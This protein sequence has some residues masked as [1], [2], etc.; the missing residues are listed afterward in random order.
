MPPLTELVRTPHGVTLECLVTG[1]GEPTT[2]FAHG[3]GATITE[4]RPLGSGVPGRKVFFQFRGHGA[5]DAP[6]EPWT[7]GDLARDLRAIADQT[8]ATRALGVS[9]GAGALCRLLADSPER[10]DRVVLFL[11]A[12][13]DRPRPAPAR[14]RLTRLR[15]AIAAGDPQPLA[16]LVL[17]DVHPSVQDTPAA[18]AFVRA[19]IDALLRHGLAAGLATL[20][21]QVPVPD[22]AMLAEVRAEVLILATRDDDMHPVSVAEELAA[23]LPH[24]T[25]HVYDEPGVVWVQRTDLRD[26]ISGFLSG[27]DGDLSGDGDPAGGDGDPAGGADP[28]DR[29]GPPGHR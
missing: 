19:R 6:P 13:L 23:V 20:L 14:A 16:E 8:G 11:P 29:D 7:Y 24:A 21:D 2:I 4:T 9:L 5:S 17:R 22:R 28:S 18:T 15:E 25:L 1:S 27:G 12:V 10:F 26:R 3:L